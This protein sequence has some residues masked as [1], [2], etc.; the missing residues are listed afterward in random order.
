ME[1]KTFQKINEERQDKWCPFVKHWVAENYSNALA[2]ETGELCNWI[3]KL[4]RLQHGLVPI[5]NDPKTEQE[6]KQQIAEEIADIQTYLSLI[7]S[8]FSLDLETIVIDK[9]NKVSDRFGCDIKL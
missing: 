7:S 4:D 8:Y 3:K 6:L 9:F 2:G 5:G 1:F